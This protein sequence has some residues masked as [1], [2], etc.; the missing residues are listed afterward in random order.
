ME[1]LFYDRVL[2]DKDGKDEAAPEKVDTSNY[3]EDKLS[4]GDTLHVPMVSTV[5]GQGSGH[6]QISRGLPSL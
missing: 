2:A 1:Y 4:D 3:P 5:H 6:T